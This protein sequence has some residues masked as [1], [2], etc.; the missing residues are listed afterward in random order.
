[1]RSVE[2]PKNISELELR[3]YL[4]DFIR[5]YPDPNTYSGMLKALKCFY[6]RYLEIDVTKRFKFP[7]P[8]FKPKMVPTKKELKEFYYA[9]DTIKEKALFLIFATSGLRKSEV[10]SLTFKDVDF[11]QR[12][13]FPKIHYGLSKRSWISFYNEEA[14]ED[15]MSYLERCKHV[16]HQWHRKIRLFNNTDR[17]TEWKKARRTTGLDITPRILRVWFC[18]EMARLGVPDRYV[19]AFCGRVPKTILARYYTDYSPKTLKEIYDRANLKVLS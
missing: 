3:N 13:L 17:P 9:L 8:P 12:M 11:S 10:L 16:G 6:Q 19:D 2:D 7:R 15:L 5:R 18:V 4:T 14:E 1:L